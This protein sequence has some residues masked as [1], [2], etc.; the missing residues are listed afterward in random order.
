VS[1]SPMRLGLQRGLGREHI[2]TFEVKMQGFMHFY[3]EKL[4]AARSRG[5]YSSSLGVNCAGVKIL[6]QVQLPSNPRQVASWF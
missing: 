6:Q 3:S 1:T 2:L 4:L 5:A